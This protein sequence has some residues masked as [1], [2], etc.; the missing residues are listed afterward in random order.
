[1]DFGGHGDMPFRCPSK[2][3][4]LPAPVSSSNI[5]P[6]PEQPTFM[7]NRG[8]GYKS[9][10]L[11]V[12]CGQTVMCC[13]DDQGSGRAYTA[14][15]ILLLPILLHSLPFHRCWAQKHSL[16]NILLAN[17]HLRVWVLEKST[18]IMNF[19]LLYADSY[20]DKFMC[21]KLKSQF[22]NICMPSNYL[23]I[24]SLRIHKEN[25]CLQN[26]LMFDL[27]TLSY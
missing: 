7:A 8:W 19:Y 10:A 14:A 25:K 26:L 4:F 18:S 22:S 3:N 11:L 15:Q 5:I 13:G 12:Q 20:M 2:E 21:I 24:Y 27:Q 23:F 6:F 9:P 17:F 16:V 1:M